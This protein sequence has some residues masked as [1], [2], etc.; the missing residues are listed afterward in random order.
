[1]VTTLNVFLSVF[2]QFSCGLLEIIIGTSNKIYILG[3]MMTVKLY[4]WL[5]ILRSHTGYT[6]CALDGSTSSTTGV[7]AQ[8]AAVGRAQD[9]RLTWLLLMEVGLVPCLLLFF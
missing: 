9:V 2:L 6:W 4:L 3:I 7:G 1:M 8:T 5:G